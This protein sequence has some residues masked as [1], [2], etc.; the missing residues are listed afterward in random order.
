MTV[1][2][3]DHPRLSV[4]TSLLDE[5]ALVDDLVGRIA[6]AC[7]DLALPFE[8]VVVDDGSRDGTLAR[9]LALSA[10]IP[11]LKVVELSRNFGHMPA[12]GAG[13]SL[14]RGD[15]VVI[16]DGDLQDPPELIGRFVEEWRKGAD[17]VYGLRTER[18]EGW[19]ARS[20]TRAFYALLSRVSSVPIPQDAGTFS[21][22]DRRVADTLA[23]LPERE[24][25]LA[26]LRAWAGGRQVA[27]PYA[28]PDRPRGPSRVGLVGRTG[29]A[30]V[31]LT[32]FSRLP[33]RAVSFLSLAV[34]VILFSIGLTAI[35]VR[36]FTDLAIPGWATFTTLVGMTGFVQSLVL[37][38]L[39]EYVSVIFEEVKRRPAFLVRNVYTDGKPAEGVKR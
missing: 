34:G 31:A 26:G 22:L 30:A 32:S 39:S 29:L 11:E 1:S 10:R 13:L 33:L 9:L 19:L 20:L 25:F 16:M 6:A 36:L 24:R 27:V 15:A 21:L 12:L 28:R 23:A 17:V 7:R 18:G 8:I 38:V 14:A 4:V 35:L 3:Q 5:E 37:A 2:A